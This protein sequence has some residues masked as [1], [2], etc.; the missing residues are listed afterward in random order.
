MRL[1]QGPII[2]DFFM[3]RTGRH[4]DEAVDLLLG[5]NFHQAQRTHQIDLGIFRQV[6]F[7]TA[8]RIAGSP[9]RVVNDGVAVFQ[10]R[11]HA[12]GIFQTSLHP[13]QFGVV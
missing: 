11:R 3:D 6:S 7:C 2:H 9:E 12:A 13:V 10:K 5:R 1:I 4:V 8:K